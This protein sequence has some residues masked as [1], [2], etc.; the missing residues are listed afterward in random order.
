MI[1]Q[2]YGL[3]GIFDFLIEKLG[4]SSLFAGRA[5]W[6]LGVISEVLFWDSYY[7]TEGLVWPEKYQLK[8]DESLPLQ[9]RPAALI[10]DRAEVTILDVGAGPMTYLGKV[11]NGKKLDIVAVDPLA[12][13]YDKILSKYNITPP[14]KTQNVAGEELLQTFGKDKFDLAFARNSI[15][16]SVDP[17]QTILQ[18]LD[19]TKADGFVLLEH[20]PNEAIN[21]NYTGLHQWNF[22]INDSK[23]FIISSKFDSVNMT[24]K[25]APEYHFSSKLV[26]EGSEWLVVTISKNKPDKNT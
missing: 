17:E 6:R 21:E 19:V 1:Y 22:S 2:L 25:Y 3:R 24:K 14:I 12:N 11:H 20:I 8:F 26:K 15:D 5:R 13:A 18:M 9:P 4:L 10:D 23:E 7:R 16:H